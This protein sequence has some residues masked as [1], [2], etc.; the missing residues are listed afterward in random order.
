MSAPDRKWIN[1][2]LEYAVLVI[3]KDQGMPGRSFFQLA[4]SLGY[5][6]GDEEMFWKREVKK[7]YRIWSPRGEVS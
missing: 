2:W 3:R 1:A 7:V 4:R 5:D 6:T